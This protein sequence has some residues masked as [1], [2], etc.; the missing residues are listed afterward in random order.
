MLGDSLFSSF[1]LGEV[2]GSLN[3]GSPSYGD[4]A[5]SKKRLRYNAYC[6][7]RFCAGAARDI[8]KP[9]AN[10]N[11]EKCPDCNYYLVYKKAEETV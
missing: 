4:L 6:T 1:V 11:A 9:V 8:L 3:K 7:S 2:K 10:R 5:T